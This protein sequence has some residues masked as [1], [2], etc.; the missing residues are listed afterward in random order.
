MTVSDREDGSLWIGTSNGICLDYNTNSG[1]FTE[2]TTGGSQSLLRN[3]RVNTIFTDDEGMAWIGTANGLNSYDPED[4]A[5]KKYFPGG[6]GS[7]EPGNEIIAIASDNR[8]HLILVTGEGI[9]YMIPQP[10]EYIRVNVPAG[11]KVKCDY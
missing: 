3:P 5:F 2:L 11:I 10:Q 9:V 4:F 7:N 8:N 6:T 1:T